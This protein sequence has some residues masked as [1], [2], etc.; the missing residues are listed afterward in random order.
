MDMICFP[1]F[2]LLL[3]ILV[4]VLAMFFVIVAKDQSGNID[5]RQANKNIE[6]NSLQS[7]NPI[8]SR[9]FVD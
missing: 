3:F 7:T 6:E 1:A 2:W 5:W 9:S 8:T 4:M